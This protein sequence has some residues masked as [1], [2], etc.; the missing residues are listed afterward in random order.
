MKIRWHEDC[1]GYAKV[2]SEVTQ[3]W[4]FRLPLQFSFQSQKL[5]MAFVLQFTFQI[6]MKSSLSNSFIFSLQLLSRKGQ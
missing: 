4:T 3:E 6:F 5:L 1:Y 2:K